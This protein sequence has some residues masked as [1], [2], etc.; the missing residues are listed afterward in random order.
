M[1]GEVKRSSAQERDQWAIRIEEELLVGGAAFSE[2][3]TLMSFEAHTAFVA[4]ADIATIIL[5]SS[6]CETH[7]RTEAN[8]FKSRF[9]ELIDSSTLAETPKNEL[10]WL[11]RTRN[12]WAHI[13][14]KT[15]STDLKCYTNAYDEAL[16]GDAK[17]SYQAMLLV[18][19][20]DQWV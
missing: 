13:K 3:A 15:A 11:R 7:L 8:D 10:H 6:A 9:I 18:L 20:S 2:W 12:D 14:R 19:F 1:N 4:G 17:R 16:E 5:C